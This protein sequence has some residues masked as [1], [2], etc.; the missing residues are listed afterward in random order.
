MA[1]PKLDTRIYEDVLYVDGVFRRDHVMERALHYR[2]KQY[3]DQHYKGVFFVG[4]EHKDEIFQESF[5]C[6]WEN[7][8]NRRIF[9]ENGILKGRGGELFSGRLMT[10]FMSIAKNKYL[11]WAR[12]VNQVLFNEL[13]V[14]KKEYEISMSNT[15]H[16]SNNDELMLEIISD[17]I[18]HLSE[19]CN[20][21]L[22]LFYYESI[23]L[24]GIL[25]ILPSFESKDAL[26]TAKYKCMDNL[27]KSANMI[28][29]R[30]I[31][32]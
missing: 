11:E 4:D 20:Q 7:I 30:R 6:L 8:I 31:N 17:C 28:L 32:V 13:E 25:R 26:K 27:R 21:I 29:Q 12:Q 15:Q 18:S 19:C 3:F 24:D 23:N 10:Y 22:T 2:C 1:S 14:K 16:D 9:V 5:I